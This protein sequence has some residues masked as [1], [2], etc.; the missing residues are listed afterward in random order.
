MGPVTTK[1]AEGLKTIV[2]T[3][4][5]TTGALR[6]LEVDVTSGGGGVLLVYYISKLLDRASLEAWDHELKASQEFPTFEQ[7]RDF[8]TSHS[9]TLAWVETNHSGPPSP[10]EKGPP[11]AQRKP[12]TAQQASAQ[13]SA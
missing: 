3:L 12:A 2:V 1:T 10:K 4:T 6:S 7:L 13:P 5:K 9:D 11:H 8:S